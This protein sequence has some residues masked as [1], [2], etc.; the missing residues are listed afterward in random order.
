VIRVTRLVVSRP[1]YA[2]D[3]GT[4]FVD[5]AH[6]VRRVNAV[7]FK[8]RNGVLLATAGHYYPMVV[9][10]DDKPAAHTYQAWIDAADDNRY[11]GAWTAR[12]NG[13][14]TWFAEQE[15]RTGDETR[16]AREL[17]AA[18]LA[19]YPNPPAGYDGWYGFPQKGRTR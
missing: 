13:E 4:W 1:T 12:S 6:C 11:G 15:Y 7:W 2:F 10:V 19:A 8:R 9:R 18:A 16:R 14:I 17:L 5:D 3:P